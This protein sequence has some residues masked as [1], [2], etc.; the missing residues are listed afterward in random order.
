M[1]PAATVLH[2]EGGPALSDF[3]ARALLERLQRVQP[4][5]VGVSAQHVHWAAL[6]GAP[7]PDLKAQIAALLDIGD[8]AA[9]DNSGDRKSVV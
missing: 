5:V 9:A 6:A 1:L 7:T 8:T 3:R 4:R 2:F